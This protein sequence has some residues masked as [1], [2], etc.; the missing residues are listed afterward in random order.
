VR[1]FLI[2][3]KL[4]V[5]SGTGARHRGQAISLFVSSSRNRL[6]N[7]LLQLGHVTGTCVLLKRSII[8]SFR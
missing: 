6:L 2:A 7:V 8:D 5:S 3:L 1:P 4:F